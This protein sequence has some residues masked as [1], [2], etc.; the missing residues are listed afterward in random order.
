MDSAEF[1]TLK[2]LQTSPLTAQVRIKHRVFKHCTLYVGEKSP[3][4][5]TLFFKEKM[6][7]YTGK[8]KYLPHEVPLLSC[9]KSGAGCIIWR[10]MSPKQRL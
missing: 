8:E 10:G 5:N 2:F 7:A 1:L 4:L 6:C 9:Q 3:E